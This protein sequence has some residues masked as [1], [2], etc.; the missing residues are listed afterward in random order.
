MPTLIFCSTPFHAWT[1]PV[2]KFVHVK[3]WMQNPIFALLCSMERKR[4]LLL[5]LEE[6]F[7]QQRMLSTW[8]CTS[9]PDNYRLIN[10]L[11][12]F[13]VKFWLQ[14]TT[15]NAYAGW[16]QSWCFF[17]HIANDPFIMRNCIVVNVVYWLWLLF[18]DDK[19]IIF[20]GAFLIA[21][22]R[23]ID[24]SFSMLYS[25]FPLSLIEASII[26]VHFTIAISTIIS[27]VSFVNVSTG[28][29]K[30]AISWLF[31][32]R[33][34]S[35]VLITIASPSLPQPMSIS[36]SIFEISFEITAICPIVLSKT[37]RFAIHIKP[38]VNISIVKFLNS[39]TML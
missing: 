24:F 2:M 29:C 32:V 8:I 13:R 25:I 28:P 12:L 27:I 7:W 38:L 16:T 17:W 1:S 22:S 34:L 23:H 10:R 30:N 4:I 20:K 36:E 9:V 5:C 33:I 19:H 39:L 15:S 37:T 31:I 35:L 3:W 6:P 21:W 26:P 14:T 18:N 11:C